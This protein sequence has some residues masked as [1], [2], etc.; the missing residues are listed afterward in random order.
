MDFIKAAVLHK[1]ID[2]AQSQKAKLKE[3][4]QLLQE[5]VPHYDWIGF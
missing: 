2:S 4:C 1:I 3:I 5:K